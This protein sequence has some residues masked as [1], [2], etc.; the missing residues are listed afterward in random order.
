[1]S[2]LASVASDSS[3][4]SEALVLLGSSEGKTCSAGKAA[5]PEEDA[6]EPGE[7]EDVLM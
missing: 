5:G 6:D 7:V 3:T 4:L 1:M 2:S